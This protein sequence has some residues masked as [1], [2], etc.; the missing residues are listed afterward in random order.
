M[1]PKARAER[2]E[3]PVVP[4]APDAVPAPVEDPASTKREHSV[5][6]GPIESDGS[7]IRLGSMEEVL[8]RDATQKLIDVFPNRQYH[9]TR[10]GGIIGPHG[11]IRRRAP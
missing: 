7:D 4:D 11:E 6:S 9:T 1:G 3:D 5:K 10:D 8:G 2:W